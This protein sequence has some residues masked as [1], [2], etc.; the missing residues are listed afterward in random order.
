MAD[1]LYLL[2]PGW[3]DGQGGPW[4]C[5]AGAV[6]EGVLGFYPRLREEL[7]VTY[8]DHPRP[9]PAVVAEVGEEHQGCPILVIDETVDWPAA[10]ISVETGRRFLQDEA[11]IPY[12]T[13][14]YGIGRPHP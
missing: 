7:Q 10:R 13:A 1:R 6:I 12:L 4:F 8:L 2:N 5:P 11:I 3:F 9:R 14:R